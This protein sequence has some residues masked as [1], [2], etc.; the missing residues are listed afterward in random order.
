MLSFLHPNA[1]RPGRREFLQLGGLG[2]GASAL[3]NLW[4]GN[5]LGSTG[6]NA[7]T[8]KSV[9]FLF[10]QGGPSQYET[11][12]PKPEI[13]DTM[14]TVGEVTKTAIPGVTFGG[15]MAR[16]AKLADRLAV[17]RSFYTG[18]DHGKL[19][20]IVS[21]TTGNAS[22]NS[23][24]SRI[25]GTSNPTTGLPSSVFLKPKSIDDTQA[26]LA[27]RFGKFDATGFLGAGYAPFTPG[28]G[29]AQENLKLQVAPDRLEDRQNLLKTL[30]RARYAADAGGSLEGMTGI[31][32]R[33]FDAL[34]RGVSAAFDLSKED[35]KTLARYDTAS[36]F[37][38]ELWGKKNNSKWYTAHIQTV[39]KL[40]LLAR[41]LCE[42]GCGM[43]TIHTEFVWD[44]HQDGNNVGVKEG[45]DIVMR[46]F[47]HAVS[48]FIEDVEAR[49]LSDK[50]LLVCCGEMGRT[51]KLGK[52][53]GRGHWPSLAP[54]IMHGGGLTHG[55]VIG[56]STPDGGKPAT[57]PFGPDN[58]LST[59]VRT[60]IDNGQARL[61]PGLPQELV[62][63]LEKID[64]TPGIL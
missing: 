20:P 22:I 52:D 49:G 39:G 63:I 64:K 16:L 19:K 12:D 45:Q 43:I 50:I 23:V 56:A 53:A 62:R 21:E 61:I 58:L 17:V 32:Q 15:S 46:P 28:S 54:L 7:M 4:A 9:V 2:L 30:D 59:I 5:A 3:S 44:M 48:A 57:K 14:R 60:L 47:D 1:H 51:P 10:M 25:V 42:A 27:E 29:I 37:K 18:T 13:P 34:M 41:R 33:A 31:Q 55:Q 35:P 36:Y 24:Y 11:F 6:K 38:P 40:M 8:G 26:T